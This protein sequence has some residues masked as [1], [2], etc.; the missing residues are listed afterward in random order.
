MLLSASVQ[1][2]AYDCRLTFGLHLSSHIT[3]DNLKLVVVFSQSLYVTDGW[4]AA[5][6]TAEVAAEPAETLKD[7]PA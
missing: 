2:R 4:K 6:D 1:H 3:K 5:G 7:T